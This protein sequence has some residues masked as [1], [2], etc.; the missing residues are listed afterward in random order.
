MHVH[1]YNE[2]GTITTPFD[3]RVQNKMDRY[4]LV[5]D[6]LKYV[7]KYPKEGEILKMYCKDMLKKH[8]NTIGKTGMDIEEVESWR[9]KELK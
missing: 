2:E 5:L 9:W 1:G 4:N 6:V 8:A 7:K 3:M